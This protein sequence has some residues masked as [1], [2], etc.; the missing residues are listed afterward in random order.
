MPF[1]A[2][3]R[4]HFLPQAAQD[5]PGN[6]R[7]RRAGLPLDSF[8]RSICSSFILRR[9]ERFI[10]SATLNSP[11]GSK[12][13]Q[14]HFS[15]HIIIRSTLMHEL[16]ELIKLGLPLN[17]YI[18]RPRC[19]V[20]S[21]TCPYLSI[22][23]I[24]RG[25]SSATSIKPIDMAA[26][27]SQ[28]A[29]ISPCNIAFRTTPRHSHGIS[30]PCALRTRM[31]YS[32]KNIAVLGGSSG[33]GLE[34]SKYLKSAGV[35]VSAF[36]RRTRHDFSKLANCENALSQAPG[37]LALCFG[38][39]RRPSSV[40]QEVLMYR[41]VAVAAQNAQSPMLV[42]V[43]RTIVVQEVRH[44]LTN[45][46]STPWVILRPGAMDIDQPLPISDGAPTARLHETIFITTDIRCNGLISRQ[47]VARVVGDLLFGGVPMKEVDGKVLGVYDRN[48]MISMP[49]GAVPFGNDI[50]GGA[51]I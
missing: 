10:Y 33:V 23:L 6:I 40:D 46:L 5:S 1:Q 19:L 7:T 30:K 9:L 14:N 22:V 15:P 47:S 39:G 13:G 18:S 38:A 36:S 49:N 35:S 42:A 20:N 11:H 8:L 3:W 44:I 29:F 28:S 50:W 24:Y 37:G 21:P 31:V 43:V 32:G 34:T 45:V 26:S 4:F 12:Y 51:T 2:F 27:I 48:R 25:S 41:N 17:L 16:D